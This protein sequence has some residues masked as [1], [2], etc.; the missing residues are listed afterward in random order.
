LQR[1]V[2]RRG[3]DEGHFAFGFELAFRWFQFD[4]GIDLSEI[5]NTASASAILSF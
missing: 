1:A 5:V 4:L 3:D 2:F